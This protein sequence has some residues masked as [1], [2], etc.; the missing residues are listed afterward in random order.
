MVGEPLVEAVEDFSGAAGCCPDDARVGLIE[1]SPTPPERH[2]S[3]ANPILHP[4][5]QGHRP[6][7]TQVRTTARVDICHGRRAGSWS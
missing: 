5:N 1:C 2:G 6:G 7:S 4:L 3:G